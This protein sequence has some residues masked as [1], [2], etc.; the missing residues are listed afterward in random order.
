M[1]KFLATILGRTLEK[2]FFLSDFRYYLYINTILKPSQPWQRFEVLISLS[3]KKKI[4]RKFPLC[5]S[6]KE[7]DQYP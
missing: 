7:H 4:F 2:A 3:I 5:L 1:L 6:S